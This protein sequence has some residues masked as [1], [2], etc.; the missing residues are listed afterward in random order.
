MKYGRKRQ[1]AR[2]FGEYLAAALPYLP[3]DTVV[4][5]I[6]TAS[7]RIRQRGFDQARLIGEALAKVLSLEL[8]RPLIRTTQIDLVG[9]NRQQ[10]HQ[11]MAQSFRLKPSAD[12]SGASILLVDDVLTTGATL[13]AAAKLLRQHGA[14]HVDAAV[15]ARHLLS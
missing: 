11:Y 15:V 4:L 5:P 12:I 8:I 2:M 10:R 3:P 7:Q 1:H 14:S 9:K 6:P 13:E